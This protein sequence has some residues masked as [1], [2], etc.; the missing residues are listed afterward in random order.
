M[1]SD[2][3]IDL[4]L[5]TIY[6]GYIAAALR[7]EQALGP[8]D[9]LFGLGKKLSDDP[10]HR[11][12]YHELEVLLTR[13]AATSP[14]SGAVRQAL[15]RIYEAPDK[16]AGLPKSVYW[17]MVAAQ[18]LTLSLIPFL[19]ADD[20]AG[21]LAVCRQAVCFKDPF[22]AQKQVLKELKRR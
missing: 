12:F 11:T 21:L 16:E 18:G 6:T 22:P 15:S 20:A 1:E 7:A 13:F 2:M 19:S 4:E 10:C 14:E 9:G 8:F 17:G 5:E 3:T